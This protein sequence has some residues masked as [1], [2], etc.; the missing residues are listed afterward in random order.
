[1][2]ENR[3]IIGSLDDDSNPYNYPADVPVTN[4]INTFQ[5]LSQPQ[6]DQQDYDQGEDVQKSFKKK[7]SKK[8]IEITI[9]E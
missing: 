1:M 2:E 5:M 3:E 9:D 6:D 8:F 7:K 4:Y